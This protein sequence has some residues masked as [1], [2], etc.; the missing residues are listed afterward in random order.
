M[1]PKGRVVLFNPLIPGNTGSIARSCVALDFELILIHPLGFSLSE[2]SLRRA[3]LDYWKFLTL[4]EYKNFEEFQKSENPKEKEL[5]FFS[6]FGAQ[7]FLDTEYSEDAFLIFGSETEGLPKSFHENYPK[8]MYHL[9]MR[10]P[11]VR[12]LNLANAATA[13]M[14]LYM[15]TWRRN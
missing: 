14:Y 2:K 4:K 9:P 15:R 12:S 13:A 6:K 10:S 7:S 8:Q 5:F 1:A 3:G 11:N